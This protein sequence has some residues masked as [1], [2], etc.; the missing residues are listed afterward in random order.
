MTGGERERERESEG[1]RE[2]GREGGQGQYGVNVKSDLH[3]NLYVYLLNVLLVCI[4]TCTNWMWT[5][6]LRLSL[7]SELSSISDVKRDERNLIGFS[8]FSHFR[9]YT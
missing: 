8:T 3:T 4:I 1:G 7:W 5:E 2:G 9:L 6:D